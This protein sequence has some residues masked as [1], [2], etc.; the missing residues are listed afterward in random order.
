MPGQGREI[1]RRIKSIKSTRQITKAMELVSAAKMRR[2]VANV[3]ATRPYAALAWDMVKEISKNMHAGAHALLA[4]RE[5]IKKI[6]LIL[7]TSNRGLAGSFNANVINLARSFIQRHREEGKVEAD[8]VIMGKKGR[9]VAVKHGHTVIAEFTKVD[10]TTRVDE[11]RPLAKLV[12]EEYLKGTYDRIVMVYTDFVSTLTQKP[13]VKQLLPIVGEDP[14]LG[15]VG[16]SVRD[17]ER[18]FTQNQDGVKSRIESRE[19]ASTEEDGYL[20]E[21]SSQAVLDEL[22]PRL[23][24]IQIYQAILESDASEHSARMLAMQNAS[25]AAGDMMQELTLLYNRTRQAAIT[26]E[27]AEISAGRI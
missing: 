5:Q 15:V 18:E 14:Y 25:E 8:L 20:F 11:V 16:A 3:L 21:P 23:V 26:Q 19:L 27:I 24:E 17:K 7:I 10:V 9:D 12:M 22:L 13:R 1:R 6:G 4:E 2:A